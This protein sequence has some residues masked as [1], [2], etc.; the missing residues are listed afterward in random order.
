MNAI[1]FWHP[2]SLLIHLVP[3]KKLFAVPIFEK[4]YPEVKKIFIPISVALMC[5]SFTIVPPAPTKSTNQNVGFAG[6]LAVANSVT[7]DAACVVYIA[8]GLEERGLSETAFKQAWK[9]YQNLIN[10]NLLGRTSYLTICDFS[11]SSR[12]KRLYIVDMSSKKLIKHTYVAHG[13]NT[14]NEYA[15]S[16]SN[17]PE[18]LQSSLGFY[19]TMQTYNGENGLSLRLKGVDKGFNDN[20]LVRSIVIHGADYVS[21]G[22]AAK[23]I[24]GRSYGCPAVPKNEVSQIV[25]IIKNG[26]CLF[27]YHPDKQYR[28]SSKVL[29]E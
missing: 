15:T 9:G 27:I 5:V 7:E 21:A 22:R 20:A 14:G 11:K 16:F 25:Q 18:S 10:R 13:R 17:K 8:A 29:N 24:T 23:G 4:P 3:H 1:L 19:V 28:N 2:V 12:Q 6:K 26:T